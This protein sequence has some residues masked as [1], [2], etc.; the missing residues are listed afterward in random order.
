MKKRLLL[1]VLMIV[2]GVTGCCSGTKAKP[3][4]LPQTSTPREHNADLV[5]LGRAQYE[6]GDLE[7]A[8]R[9]LLDVLRAN[10]QNRPARYYLN[11]VREAELKKSLNKRSPGE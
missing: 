7:A 4:S 10:P 9:T 3:S 11:L 5:R 6:R 2:V 8:T 1:P